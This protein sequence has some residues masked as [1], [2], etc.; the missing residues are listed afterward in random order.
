MQIEN[1]QLNR[2]CKNKSKCRIGSAFIFVVGI[3]AILLVIVLFFSRSTIAKRFS[4]KLLSNEKKA[5]ALAEAAVDLGIRYIKDHMNNEKTAPNPWY[6]ILRV[7]LL[8]DSSAGVTPGTLGSTSG[9]DAPL[10]LNSDLLVAYQYSS[11]CPILSPL[12]SVI[13][14]LGGTASVTLNILISSAS[15]ITS[16]DPNYSVTGISEKSTPAHGDPGKFYDTIFSYSGGSP[17]NLKNDLSSDYTL[18]FKLPV[19]PSHDV[20][21]PPAVDVTLFLSQKA[22]AVI[23]YKIEID[24]ALLTWTLNGEIDCNDLVK[25][26]LKLDDVGGSFSM[27]NLV[28]KLMNT[29]WE[30]ISW[31]TSYLFQAASLRFQNLPSVI[32]N[33]VP[34]SFKNDTFVEKTGKIRFMAIVEFKPAANL[35]PVRR[36]LIAEKDLKVSDTMP[37]APEYTFFVANS[38]RAVESPDPVPTGIG[39]ELKFQD[40]AQAATM[41]IHNLPGGEYLKLS[42]G[43]SANAT[44]NLES[45]ASFPGMVRLNYSGPKAMEIP[46]Y[47][48]TP[49]DPLSSE[50]NALLMDKKAAKTF[51]CIFSA[52]WRDSPPPLYWFDFP[53]TGKLDN[54]SETFGPGCQELKKIISF[55]EELSNP[56][57]LFGKFHL[58]Y[59]LS[60]KLEGYLDMKYSRFAGQVQPEHDYSDDKTMIYSNHKIGKVPYGL[61]DYPA[62]DTSDTSRWNPNISANLPANL[63]SPLQYAKKANYF[64][65]NES[66]FWADSQRFDAD[67]TFLCNGVTYIKGNLKISSPMKVKGRGILVAKDVIDVYADIRRVHSSDSPTVFSLIARRGAIL[68]HNSCV[69]EAACF[70]N[71]CI[72]NKSG[73]NLTIK[74]NLVINQFDRKSVDGIEVFYESHSLSPTMLAMMRDVGKYEPK[75]YFCSIGARWTRFDYA[76]N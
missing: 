12:G 5:E 13:Q 62:Y 34:N 46:I 33:S 16:K 56:V 38:S 39:S 9:L 73:N 44:T 37:V 21:G 3:L 28:A 36:I 42:D 45:V 31:N 35:V 48:G 76:K 7:P 51:N 47:L 50:F 53:Y 68:V 41:T 66:D 26:F 57:L 15:A 27:P 54:F 17:K 24:V 30:S 43:F 11:T 55:N 59:P 20:P 1:Y 2:L 65:E 75:R 64:Y 72:M 23:A 6:A 74:G 22:P 63:Y 32:K 25:K 70:S 58:E 52:T 29:G 14:N 18:T 71:Q 40:P 4:T 49:N 19:P 69:I 67:G 60:L 10:K 61:P 8:L